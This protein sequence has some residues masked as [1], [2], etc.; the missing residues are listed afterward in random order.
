MIVADG[1]IALVVEDDDFQRRTVARMLRSMGALEVMEAGNGKQAMVVL[2]GPAWVD[3]VVCDLDMPEMDGMEFLRHLGQARDSAAVI[4]CS[5]QNRSLLLSVEKMARAYGVR[6]LGAIEKPVTCDTMENLIALY[7]PA[8]Q[9]ARVAGAV[10]GFS[11]NQVLSGLQQKQFESFFQP[12]AEMATGR[13][14]GAEALARW[15]HPKHGLVGPNA[16]ISLLEKSGNIDQLTFTLLEEAVNTCRQWRERGWDLTISVN[17]SLAS[18]SDTTLADRITA[19]VRLSGLGPDCVIFEIMETVAMTE[20][21]AALENLARLRMRGFGLSV[22]DYGT[23]FSNLQQL[24][25]VPF[26]EIKID[27]EFVKGCATNPS[28]RTIVEL[29]VEM[30]RRLGIKSVAE[31]VETQEEW[32]VLKAAGC[33]QAQGYFIA[34]PLDRNSFLAFCTTESVS[35]NRENIEPTKACPPD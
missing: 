10:T 29:S 15:R 3:L 26:T 11:L 23:G 24:T 5:A 31:G 34:R 28:S 7:R 16:F 2:S 13:T 32:D 30:A 25:R 19:A 6:L 22:D 17:L 33:D 4:I 35:R 21:A 8:T 1:L 14:I 9:A 27:Q 18:L 20:V 12:K